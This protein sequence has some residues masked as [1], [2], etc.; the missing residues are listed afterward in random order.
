[1]A[2]VQKA[3]DKIQGIKDKIDEYNAILSKIRDEYVGKINK[4]I[5]D[6]ESAVNTAIDK[7]NAGCASAQIWLEKK[8]Q[9][10]TKQIQD[11]LNKLK[12]KIK[13]IID[14]LKEWYDTTINN[15]KTSVVKSSSVKLG[16][17]LPDSAVNTMAEAIPHPPFDIDIDKFVP[18]I[19][20]GS[21]LPDM[22]QLKY[23]DKISIPKI[24]I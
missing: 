14:Q 6:L 17:R 2:D 16:I 3:L 15:V 13:S 11:I 10:I 1:M 19:D 7:I 5:E 24:Q 21:Y 4:C 20:V 23:I 9:K 8:V 18:N 22:Q 12:D